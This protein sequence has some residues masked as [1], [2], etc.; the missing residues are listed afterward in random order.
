MKKPFRERIKEGPI[1]CDGAMGTLLDLYEYPEL[2]HEIQNL[3]NPGI[4]ERLHREYIEAGSEIIESNTFSAN[5]LRLTQFRLQD[6]L[7]EINR[8]GVEIAKR[9][10]GD[11]VYVAGAIGPIGMLLEPIGKIK[12]SQARDAFKEQAEILIEEG[13]DLIMLETF[14]SVQELDEALS[15]VKALTDI[16]IVAQKAFAEDGAILSGSFPIEVI[17]HLIEQ[18]ADIVGANCTVGPQRMFT[19]IRNVHKD[20][21]ILSA[22]PA[23]GI[24]TLLNGRSIYHTTPEY[25]AAYAKEL[26]EAGV[27]LVG[28]CCG[29]TPSHIR[30]IAQAVKGLKVGKPVTKIDAR[31][32]D[33]K[34]D[35]PE[36]KYYVNPPGGQICPE[37]RD[38]IHD[39]RRARHP[40]RHRYDE[41]ARN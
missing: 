13:V 28:A 14:V 1:V 4:I 37:R 23:A 7:R 34:D 36:P 12:R 8:K 22:Q 39:D 26:V 6:Q 27:T 25:L 24:P 29:S 17:E 38:K 2:P 41:R 30:A 3:K 33:R 15:A 16:P 5:R 10:A 19:I 11:N 20:G 32:H 35:H 40:A 31:T 18:G 21:V 9:A